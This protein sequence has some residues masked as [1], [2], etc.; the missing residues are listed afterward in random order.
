MKHGGDDA[1]GAVRGSGDD[2]SARGVIFAGGE[3]EAY[4]VTRLLDGRTGSATRL[5]ERL[6]GARA[7]TRNWNTFQRLLHKYV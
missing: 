1:R 7:T 4:S 6:T 2:A 3:K 5:V